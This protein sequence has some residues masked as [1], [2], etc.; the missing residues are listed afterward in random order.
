MT[1][2]RPPLFVINVV[3]MQE[4]TWSPTALPGG[5]LLKPSVGCAIGSR[6][7]RKYSSISERRQILINEHRFYALP[8]PGGLRRVG[9]VW[10]IN[11][12]FLLFVQ[13]QHP[14]CYLL[15]F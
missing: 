9:S 5:L 15:C 2:K 1:K 6:V 7:C 4:P 11:G 3:K 10:T 12:Q 14:I 13:R 8:Q